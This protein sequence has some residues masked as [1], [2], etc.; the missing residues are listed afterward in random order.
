MDDVYPIFMLLEENRLIWTI[1]E[2][3]Y[4][5]KSVAMTESKF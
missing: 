1:R 5:N 2:S 4:T 3:K